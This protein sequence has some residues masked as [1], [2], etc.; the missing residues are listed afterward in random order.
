VS[1]G[2]GPVIKAI[3]LGASALVLALGIYTWIS[4]SARDSKIINAF[5]NTIDNRIP[6]GEGFSYNGEGKIAVIFDEHGVHRRSRSYSDLFT[7]DSFQLANDPN[8]VKFLIYIKEDWIYTGSYTSGGG[9]H[10]IS[11]A[12]EI[13]DPWSGERIDSESFQ[14]ADPPK[15]TT[16]R[17]DITGRPPEANHVKDRIALM[18][19]WHMQQ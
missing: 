12:V 13:F 3:C 8:E 1:Q 7:P 10:R 18:L 17:G 2:G 16:S 9:A 14:G 5:A 6:L 11:Y 4:H 15:R 19:S